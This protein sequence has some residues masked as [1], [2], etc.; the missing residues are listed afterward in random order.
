[1]LLL[2]VRAEAYFEHRGAARL[3]IDRDT[4][5]LSAERDLVRRHAYELA[6]ERQGLSGALSAAFDE[7]AG[8]AP[9]ALVWPVHQL[10]TR[11]S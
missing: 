11:T 4:A 1:M 8:A 9:L 2:A 7:C 6:G 3:T 5:R 10:W